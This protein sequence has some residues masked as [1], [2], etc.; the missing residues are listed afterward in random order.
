MEHY[1]FKYNELYYVF[2]NDQAQSD[3]GE[4]LVKEIKK[5]S[6]EDLN[7]LKTLITDIDLS[8]NHNGNNFFYSL[9]DSLKNPH[10]Y[11]FRIQSHPVRL[12]LNRI[13]MIDLDKNHFVVRWMDNEY[14]RRKQVFLLTDIPDYW[15]Y[16]LS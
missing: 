13:Y 1:I 3:F 7:Y 16:L 10:N 5:W 15:E 14:H 6:G 12:L 9:V 11:I 8:E 4:L 2:H